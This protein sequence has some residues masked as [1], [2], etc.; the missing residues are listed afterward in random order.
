MPAR[1]FDSPKEPSK[2]SAE[3]GHSFDRTEAPTAREPPATSPS[4]LMARDRQGEPRDLM[5][6]GLNSGFVSVSRMDLS[7]ARKNRDSDKLPPVQ[8]QASTLGNR[9]QMGR[10]RGTLARGHDFATLPVPAT[11]Q[12][13]T[14]RTKKT[15]ITDRG[16]TDQEA[17]TLKEI[18]QGWKAA[19]ALVVD[20]GL[21]PS[22]FREVNSDLTANL[23]KKLAFQQ[24]DS[25]YYRIAKIFCGDIPTLEAL[26][27]KGLNSKT[28]DAMTGSPVPTARATILSLYDIAELT[29]VAPLGKLFERFPRF[30][31]HVNAEKGGNAT[32]LQAVISWLSARSGAALD[33]LE[34]NDPTFAV[35]RTMQENEFT[36][37]LIVYL[38]NFAKEVPPAN[39]AYEALGTQGKA[40]RVGHF[41]RY[42]ALR[43][44]QP[45]T[46]MT[47][48][49]KSIFDMDTTVG[50]IRAACLEFDQNNVLPSTFPHV[51][52]Y[53][54]PSLGTNIRVFNNSS[55]YNF[56]E[57]YPPGGTTLTTGEVAKL[58]QVTAIKNDWT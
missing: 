50:D 22:F 35:L 52:N 25:H 16:F 17:E 6:A 48:T 5:P 4:Q 20:G 45:N 55:A 23:Y 18:I 58:S 54:S 9:T 1:G 44:V 30:E 31:A 14:Q 42:H 38:S 47:G 13:V 28:V 15:D 33:Y 53:A 24:L 29:N 56:D 37:P 26:L 34:A 8:P 51:Y 21:T 27:E 19:A 40:Y 43:G 11:S 32:E 2:V 36:S 10:R 49:G 12:A 57:M 46:D 39:G 3:L 41:A 7:A